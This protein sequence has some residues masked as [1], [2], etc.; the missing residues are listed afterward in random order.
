M[1]WSFYLG[2]AVFLLA[3]LWT[4]FSS[5]EYSPEEIAEF[6]AGEDDA[7][8]RPTAI[9]APRQATAKGGLIWIVSAALFAPGL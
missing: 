3:V 6:E 2:G 9:P 1:K 4:V 5:K 8:E 7:V